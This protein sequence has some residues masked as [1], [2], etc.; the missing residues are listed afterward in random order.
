MV[1]LFMTTTARFNTQ[2]SCKQ[3]E[4]RLV[5]PLPLLAEDADTQGGC[6]ELR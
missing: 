5:K 1:L 6:V 2:R 4:R 3:E